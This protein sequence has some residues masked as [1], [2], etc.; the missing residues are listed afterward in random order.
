MIVDKLNRILN[1][2]ES[3][4]RTEEN[5]KFVF[6]YI[7]KEMKKKFYKENGLKQD[8]ASEIAFYNAYFKETAKTLNFPIEHFY[9]PLYKTVNQNPEY[10][11]INNKYL[12]IVFQSQDFKSA[13]KEFLDNQFEA[14]YAETIKSKIKKRPLVD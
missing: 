8:K 10:K 2:H 7:T 14:R 3:S 12:K 6:K 5:N 11:S 9:D 4:K 1:K 13:F